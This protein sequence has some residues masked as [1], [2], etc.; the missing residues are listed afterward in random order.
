MFQQ[1][2]L[3][4]YCKAKGI[5]VIGYCPIGSPN[6][7]ERDKTSGDVVD[8]ELP[9]VAAV[10]KAHSIHPALVCL[11]WAVQRG[12]IPIPFSVHEK[13]YQSN[14]WAVTEDPLSREEMESLKKA[15]RNCRLVKGQVFLWP[16]AKGWDDLWDLDG[17]ITKK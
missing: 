14:L 7:P 1:Q 10:A 15:E 16:G 8:T 3:F 4:D 9:E 5:A 12:S 6:R 17:T 11:K 2:A 13:N